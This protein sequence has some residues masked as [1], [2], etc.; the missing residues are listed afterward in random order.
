MKTLIFFGPFR[1]KYAI[2]KGNIWYVRRYESYF[3]K[4]YIV[5]LVG[6]LCEPI[7]QGNTSLVSLGSGKRIIDYILSPYR[8]YRFAKIIKPTSY[9][10]ADQVFSWWTSCLVRLILGAK[11]FL[12]PVCMPE[13]IYKNSNYK[14]SLSGI[15]P[16]WVERI[17]IK[18][19]FLSSWRVYTGNSFGAFVNWLQNYKYAKNKII[20]TDKLVESFPSDDFFKALKKEIRKERTDEQIKLIYVG[21]LH[22]EKLVIDLIKM[23]AI[24]NRECPDSFKLLLIGDGPEKDNL[25]KT[26]KEL[27]VI[28]LVDFLGYLKNDRIVPYLTD[29]KSIFTSPMTGTS[30]REAGFCGIPIVAYNMDWISGLLKH[31]E[32]VLFVPP[33]DYKGMSQQ[34]LKL[35][36]NRELW[37]RLSKNMKELSLKLWSPVGMHET[38][39]KIFGE[40]G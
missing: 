20:V 34:I 36:N 37:E 35:K 7:L 16:I 5:Y 31:E 26:A 14:N 4:V 6:N 28:G 2:D 38:L 29:S 13:V 39:N 25:I 9:L 3:D 30:L 10:T 17:L 19:S 24:L 33:G 32:T 40:N 1:R 27:N 18:L 8:L 22:H 11:I 15:L 12:M 21:R 23:L